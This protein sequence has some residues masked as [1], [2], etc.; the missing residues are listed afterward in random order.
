MFDKMGN[1][2]LYAEIENAWRGAMAVWMKLNH[3]YIHRQFS[4]SKECMKNVWNLA[5]NKDVSIA[6]KV[7]LFTTFDRYIIKKED[8]PTV[9]ECFK[10]KGYKD[11]SLSEQAEVI[12]SLYEN[13]DCIAVGWN[14]N[15]INYN[16]WDTFHN[17]KPYN[18]FKGKEHHYIFDEISYIHS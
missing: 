10:Q 7:V 1:A 18:I 13:D 4:F 5:G 14:Q 16:T 11:T 3:K 8:I 9:V 12:Q 17:G 15:S 6:D 2:E